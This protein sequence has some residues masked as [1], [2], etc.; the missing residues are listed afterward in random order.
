MSEMLCRGP[1]QKQAS[2]VWPGLYAKCSETCLTR[3]RTMPIPNMQKSAAVWPDGCL[4][5][6]AG[7]LCRSRLLQSGR[8][9]VQS[10]LKH[11]DRA[12]TLP[13][14]ICNSLQ[15]RTGQ[16]SPQMCLG[17]RLLSLSRITRD[18]RGNPHRI[19]IWEFLAAARA[20]R[21]HPSC[22]CHVAKTCWP[23]DFKPNS[24]SSLAALCKSAT[25]TLQISKTY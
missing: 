7:D 20:A 14:P 13:I 8:A 19:K 22:C 1:L 23:A 21:L 10:A 18:T 3:T 17:A 5:C 6:S 4:K 15:D 12:R 9:S 25:K 11:A 24:M 2:A 16:G